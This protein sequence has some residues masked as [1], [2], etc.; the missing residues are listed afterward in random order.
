LIR[1]GGI[2]AVSTR[3]VAAAAGVQ[4][5]VIYRLFG[6]KNQL[7]DAVT[8]FVFQD[9]LAEKRR[10]I[11]AVADPLQELEQ[12]WDLHVDFGLTHPHCYLLAYVHS[13]PGKM[14]A[15]SAQSFALLQEVVARLGNQGRLRISVERAT[16]LIRSAAMG[17]VLALISL[18]AHQRDLRISRVLRDSTLGTIVH[19]DVELQ[20]GSPDVPPTR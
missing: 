8:H 3:A 6:D 4:P 16:F 9:Y 17:L 12:M 18:P 11:A 15:C 1:T 5:P 10:L 7:L 20:K 19:T 14:S 2:D 13:R